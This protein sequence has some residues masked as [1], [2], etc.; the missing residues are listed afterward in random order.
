ML[1]KLLR[2]LDEKVKNAKALRQLMKYVV[3]V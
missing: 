3:T 1:K 2:Q